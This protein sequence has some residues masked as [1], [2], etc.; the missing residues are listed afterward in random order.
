[1]EPGALHPPLPAWLA[2]HATHPAFG[3][4]LIPAADDFRVQRVVTR[5]TARLFQ[6]LARPGRVPRSVPS[7]SLR[8]LVLDGVLEVRE[9]RRY[10]SG[11]AARSCRVSPGGMTAT[12]S[13]TGM[14]S[15]AALQDAAAL[16]LAAP[17]VLT[18]L[19]YHFNTLPASPAWRSRYADGLALERELRRSIPRSA[20]LEAPVTAGQGA[21]L[22]WVRAGRRR[23]SGT[24]WKLYV[25]PMP[26]QLVP[27]LQAASQQRDAF[28]MKVG[29]D[30]ADI[31]RP[32]K[33]VLYFA[34]QR[35]L[36]RA[37]RALERDLASV[38]AH[39]VPFTGQWGA[40]A[41]LSWGVDSGGRGSAAPWSGDDS[42]RAWLTQRLATAMV[43]ALKDPECAV[44]PW[45]YAMERVSLDGVDV[46]TWTPSRRVAGVSR[47]LHG[48]H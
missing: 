28:A 40:S 38:P 44:P 24:I 4:L 26:D 22:S 5:E 23:S 14:L 31:L 37:A 19:L 29:R 7:H 45:R 20:G 25:S 13:A 27:A 17:G 21:W 2:A 1:M 46:R 9:G 48:T 30:V 15:L 41:L 43:Q 33:L 8:A 6:R 39:G 32:D 10:L 16:Q 12:Q 35:R 47:A 18:R 36:A 34:T 3:G 42:W 11:A